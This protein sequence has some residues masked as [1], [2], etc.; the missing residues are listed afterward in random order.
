MKN[1]V[2]AAVLVVGC[3]GLADG[4][5]TYSPSTMEC[6]VDD[7]PAY[8]LDTDQITA[9]NEESVDKA[10]M[11]PARFVWYH[12]FRHGGS[13][14]QECYYS[15]STV[16]NCYFPGYMTNKFVWTPEPGYTDT[17]QRKSVRNGLLRAMSYINVQTGI[18]YFKASGAYATMPIKYSS[19]PACPA[20]GSCSLAS[21]GMQGANPAVWVGDVLPDPVE[22]VYTSTSGLSDFNL[23]R[24]VN[25]AQTCYGSGTVTAA[26]IEAAGQVAGLH[27]FMHTLGF[28]HTTAPTL[29]SSSLT[30]AMIGTPAGLPTDGQLE[31][32]YHFVPGDWTQ[33]EALD[34]YNLER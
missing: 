28:V 1:L 25:W 5:E 6:G 29:M 16:H 4:L 7:D 26:Y 21:A 24:I 34:G 11:P 14:G 9:P 8:Q 13:S 2:I 19:G 17:P 31:A 22:W 27:E 23:L 18:D 10:A 30:C 3:G 32:M 33:A 12:G 20:T 15:G